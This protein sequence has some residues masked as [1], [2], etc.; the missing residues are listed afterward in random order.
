MVKALKKLGIEGMHLNI[1]NAIYDKL[2]INIILTREK[3]KSFSL[4][5]G[6]RKR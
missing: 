4:M 1:M 2:V 5:S 3:L 6:M